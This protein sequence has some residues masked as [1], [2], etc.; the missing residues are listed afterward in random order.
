MK[1][2]KLVGK[3]YVEFD[4]HLK[5]EVAELEASGISKEEA[6]KNAP[7]M[8]AAQEMLLKWEQGDAEVKALWKM[9]NEWVYAG[10]DQTYHDLGISFHK[11]YHESETYLLGKDVVMQGVE[12]GIFTRKDDGSVWVDLTDEGLDEKLLLRSDGT[13]VY[14]TQD[15]G[16]AIMRHEEF[17]PDRMIYVVGN[18]QNYHFEVLKKVLKKMNY[19]WADNILHFSYGMVE[20]PEGKMKSREGTVV[21]ADDL[22]SEVT[23]TARQTTMELGKLENFETKEAENLFRQIGMGGLKY[24]ILKVDPAKNMMFNPSESI[25]FNGN[26]GPFIQYTYAR[27][28]SLMRKSGLEADKIAFPATIFLQ[29]EERELLI[30]CHDHVRVLHLA[31]AELSPAH[32]ANYVY[33]LAKQYNQFYQHITVLKEENKDLQHFRLFLSHFTG[34]IIE[35]MMGLLGIEVPRRM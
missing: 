30:L 26:T 4:K 17:H 2:D 3:Y 22:I 28:Q 8:L 23:E 31:A 14:M 19:E 1:G 9:M 20:L 18:E 35:K 21:D 7:L 15:L 10:F 34:S 11:T 25:D 5:L 16:T 6:A 12:K 24:F 33:D 13:S 27:I 29:D 32:I